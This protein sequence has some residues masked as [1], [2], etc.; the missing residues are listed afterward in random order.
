VLTKSVPFFCQLCVE[1][2]SSP[3]N[4]LCNTGAGEC[5]DRVPLLL[6][7]ADAIN[8]GCRCSAHLLLLGWALVS[9]K[10]SWIPEQEGF[11]FGLFHV[12]Q[13]FCQQHTIFGPMLLNI[14]GVTVV[15]LS[16]FFF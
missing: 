3:A 9:R 8:R 12:S 15:M 6:A 4:D 14:W 10:G 13:F 2:L 16:L 5:S 7:V 1:K 11:D